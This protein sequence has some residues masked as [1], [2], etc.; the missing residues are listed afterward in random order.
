M[1]IDIDLVCDTCKRTYDAGRN[2]LFPNCGLYIDSVSRAL[3]DHYYEGNPDYCDGKLYIS[4]GHHKGYQ[5]I[6]SKCYPGIEGYIEFT[7]KCDHKNAFSYKFM[8][9]EKYMCPDCLKEW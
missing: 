8:E 9:M 1:G 6:S 7:K 3:R 4:E 2:Y 5:H